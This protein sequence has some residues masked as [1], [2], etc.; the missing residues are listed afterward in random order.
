MIELTA[1]QLKLLQQQMA[2]EGI[3]LSFIRE[4]PRLSDRSDLQLSFAQQ[5]LWLLDQIEPGNPAYNISSAMRLTGQ[6]NVQALRATLTEIGRRH[7]ALRTTF[8]AVDGQPRQVIHPPEFLEWSL[9]DLSTLTPAERQQETERLIAEETLYSFDLS[10]GPLFRATLL[11]FEKRQHILTVTMHHIV[12]DGWS[13][14]VLWREFGQLYEAFLNDQPSPLRELPIQYADYAAWQRGQLTTEALAKQLNYWKEHLS[15]APALLQLPA[16]RPRP[17]VQSNRGEKF[18]LHIDDAEANALRQL[19]RA[20]GATLFMTLAAAFALLLSRYSGQAEIVMG[21]PVA[22]RN[23]REVEGLIGS[24]IN[25]LVLRTDLRGD[26]TF[27][28]LLRRERDV[29][30]RAYAHQDVLVREAD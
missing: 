18:L 29:C 13:L 1:E 7:E 26:P 27:R 16:A 17:A 15:G 23:R 10:R 5:Q 6:L 4:I 22:G 21:T 30:L 11:R 28:E 20:E 24:F 12:S 8:S 9:I 2:D 14:T 19:S 25:T 3:D